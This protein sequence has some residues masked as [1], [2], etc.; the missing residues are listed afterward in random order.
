[1]TMH[2]RKRTALSLVSMY[3]ISKILTPSPDLE[4]SIPR[5]AV[6]Y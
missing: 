6:P 3:E 1:M 2:V 4:P 5:P